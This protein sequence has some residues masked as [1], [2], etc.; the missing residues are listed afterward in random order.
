MFNLPKLRHGDPVAKM[1]V[2]SWNKIVAF[3]ETLT[4][5]GG[6]I[7]KPDNPSAADPVKIILG[8]G[9]GGS[10]ALQKG[11]ANHDWDGDPVR[12]SV[13]WSKIAEKKDGDG[14]T[15]DVM[16]FQLH[17]FTSGMEGTKLADLLEVELDKDGKPT[18]KI[19]AANEDVSKN[20]S[21]VVRKRD[22]SGGDSAPIGD[23][24]L[25][26]SYLPIGDGAGDEDD[27]DD[28]DEE[29][30]DRGAFPGSGGGGK[31]DKDRPDFPGEDDPIDMGGGPGE[32]GRESFPGEDN[33]GDF[34]GKEGPCW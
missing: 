9:S 1:S 7:R 28:D 8:D 5:V 14:F 26:V 23:N 33:R 32:E 19:L 22:G 2:R 20:F 15:T 4:V 13:K 6:S 31:D 25:E 27:D 34:P 17:K 12:K 16:G 30:C 24:G 29:D 18:G 21:I 11:D 10:G 3:L